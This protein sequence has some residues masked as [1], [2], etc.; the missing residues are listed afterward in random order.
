[1]VE[2]E[3]GE[4]SVAM[5]VLV[6]G[7]LFDNTGYHMMKYTDYT[8]ST[9]LIDGTSTKVSEDTLPLT[10]INIIGNKFTN[11]KQRHAI[12]VNSAKNVTIK[13]NVFDDLTFEVPD[14]SGRP[15]TGFAVVLRTCMNIEISDN[16]Y[17]YKHY[18]PNNIRSVISGYNFA[19]VTGTDVTNEDGTPKLPNNYT[20]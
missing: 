8:M 9:I 10:N 18:D 13:D 6:Q 12:Y 5:D 19:N 1:M 4:S 16:T 17:N 14:A 20:N 3:W 2:P 15:Q 11:S 7:C